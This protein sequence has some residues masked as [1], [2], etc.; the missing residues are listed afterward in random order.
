M[1]GYTTSIEPSMT[2]GSGGVGGSITG[3]NITVHH[4]YNVKRLALETTKPPEEAF[5]PGRVGTQAVNSPAYQ[6]LERIVRE[7]VAEILK[8]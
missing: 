4:L 8:G 7:A 1:I 2:L 5:L 6:D 3:D